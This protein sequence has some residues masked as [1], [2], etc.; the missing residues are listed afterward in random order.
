MRVL[1]AKEHETIRHRAV[2][3][4]ARF[5]AAAWPAAPT[6]RRAVRESPA[7]ACE[8]ADV[9]ARFSPPDLDT[10]MEA[11]QDPQC[12]ACGWAAYCLGQLGPRARAA[13]PTLMGALKEKDADLRRAAAQALPRIDADLGKRWAIPVLHG[14]LKDK[15]INE[16]QAA[17][18]TLEEVGLGRASVAALSNL[19]ANE[20]N[21]FTGQHLRWRAACALGK[22]GPGA[23]EAVAVLRAALQDK[24]AYMRNSAA[25]ALWQIA[26]QRDGL[27]VLIRE[28]RQ[29]DKYNRGDAA[30]K[31]AQIGPGAREALPALRKALE[32]RDDPARPQLALALWRVAQPDSKGPGDATGRDMAVAALIEMLRDR[33][34]EVRWQALEAVAAARPGTGK[35]VP[36]LVGTLREG[37]ARS[38]WQTVAALAA[39]AREAPEAV[40][41][42][43]WALDDRDDTVRAEAALALYRL[44]RRHPKALAVVKENLEHDTIAVFAREDLRLLG[45]H[46]RAAVP[47]LVQALRN[48]GRSTYLWAAGAL[49]EIDPRAVDTVWGAPAA[50]GGLLPWERLT[51]NRLKA[52]WHDLACVEAP[53]AERA[54]WTLA[55][56]SDPAVVFLRGRLR[57]VPRPDPARVARLAA[58]LGSER[59]A[60]RQ[61]A[62]V[63]LTEILDMAEP[64]LRRALAAGPP[65][66][67]RRRLEILLE[68]LDPKRSPGR[69]STLR[70]LDVLE[71][72][73]TAGARQLLK[74]L[75]GGLPEARLTREAR[76]ALD[77]LIRRPRGAS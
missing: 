42:L 16:R 46:A 54:F 30:D 67:V 3:A 69:R 37:K 29:G 36:A 53:R 4:L 63:S 14:L 28:L 44:G 23:A 76:A 40:P 25:L 62:M 70:S 39:M 32:R 66:E 9:L 48:P 2:C 34:E 12:T 13:I 26:R 31:L 64:E 71:Q 10:L 60:V 27:A 68:G 65:L 20:T 56:A 43:C 6:L 47:P 5:G 52:L 51:A 21:D 8:A 58:D 41:P 50:G 15:S 19:I 59:Y 17:F 77:R 57:P 35:L 18:Y 75:A 73:D 33:D 72:I 24:E 61:E 11:V 45:P 49:Q 38:R 74:A 1:Q 7:V 22:V 55:L